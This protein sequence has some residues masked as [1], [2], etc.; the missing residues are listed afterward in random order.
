MTDLQQ[1]MADVLAQVNQRLAQPTIAI[2]ESKPEPQ[3]ILEPET[4]TLP[5]LTEIDKKTEAETAEPGPF[6]EREAIQVVQSWVTQD[7][8][9]EFSERRTVEEMI[10]DLQDAANFRGSNVPVSRFAEIVSEYAPN[11]PHRRDDDAKSRTETNVPPY[12]AELTP[13]IKS[14]VAF[15][16]HDHWFV[17]RCRK[18]GQFK[19]AC[20]GEITH[21]SAVWHGEKRLT[22]AGR[23]AVGLD[24]IKP[25]KSQEQIDKETKERLK[26]APWMREFRGVDELEGSGTV[27]M[28]IE[29]FLPEGITLICGLPKEGKSFLAL[30][31]AKALTSGKPLFGNPRFSVPETVPVLYLA[32]ESGDGALKLR[33]EKFGISKDKMKFIARTLT[34]GP[35]FGLDD[36]NIESV[37]RTM[38]PVVI[39]ETLIRFN[40]GT[41]EDDATESRK[42]AQA[43]FRLIAFGAKAV[44]GIHHSRKDVKANPTKESAV[45]GS[46]DSL[47][48]TDA[49]WLVLQDEKLF[50]GGKGPNEIDVSGWGRDFTPWPMRLALTQKAPRNL[51]PYTLTYAPGI[52][53]CIDTTGDF[54]WVDRQEQQQE[55]SQVVE[56]LITGEPSIT[57]EK[58]VEKTGATEWEIKSTLKRLGYYRPKGGKKG[59]GPWE[60]KPKKVDSPAE[61]VAA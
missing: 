7:A 54:K 43:I 2:E 24:P 22:G 48:M 44:I 33:C 14:G 31:V 10:E 51:S 30:S 38:H 34:Q 16:Q 58:L 6:T 59:A 40:E 42:L 37:V 25:P 49:V 32:A 60:K 3:E 29:E 61:Q 15:H 1:R 36:S 12:P 45:R 23:Q 55:L 41:D 57:R 27:K 13:L 28:Y 53:S 39:L 26:N 19:T 47:A 56:G 18:C 20:C 4:E 50:Q 11:A 35:M 17:C 21:D 9:Y 5:A 8:D 52:I 46:G